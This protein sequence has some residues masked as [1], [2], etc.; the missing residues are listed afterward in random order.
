MK[1]YCQ[2]S[3]LMISDY[4]II[5]FAYVKLFNGEKKQRALT[6]KYGYVLTTL[7]VDS[8]I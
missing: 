6:E 4:I 3:F 7:V 8:K 2:I 1:I 5:Y